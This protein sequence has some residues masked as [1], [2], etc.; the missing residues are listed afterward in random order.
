MFDL[1]RQNYFCGEPRTI[2][3]PKVRGMA[4][5]KATSS[6]QFNKRIISTEC[7]VTFTLLKMGGR[8]KPLVINRLLSEDRRYGD[9]KKS[10]PGIS[11][12]MLTQSLKE[13]ETDGLIERHAHSGAR[14]HVS[15][16]LTEKGR[17]LHPILISMV[18]WAT[19]YNKFAS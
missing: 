1:R 7:P 18:D 10:I 13:L 16:T 17:D 11:E 19:K 15:Y 6:N 8:W 5:I 14:L 2:T 3:N 4:R 12:K 9:L